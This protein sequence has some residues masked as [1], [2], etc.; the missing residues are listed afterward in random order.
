MTTC[1]NTFIHAPEPQPVVQV[2]SKSV[3]KDLG[4]C[5]MSWEELDDS[6][7]STNVGS[8]VQSPAITASPCWTPRDTTEHVWGWQTDGDCNSYS[9]MGA[10]ADVP[11]DGRCTAPCKQGDW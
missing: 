5:K 8:G 11:L 9:K 7:E 4:S 3:P 6:D 2:R 10:W 1:K